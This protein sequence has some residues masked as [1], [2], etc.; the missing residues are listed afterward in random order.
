MVTQEYLKWLFSYDPETGLFTRLVARK[1]VAAGAIAG[2]RTLNGYTTISIKIDGVVSRF[3][4][5]RLAWLYIHGEWPIDVL[6]HVN[7]DRS[8]NRMIN[9]RA[10]QKNQN[11]FNARMKSSNK[12]GVKGVCWHKAMK[13]WHAQLRFNGEQQNLGFFDNLEE[14]ERIVRLARETHHGEFARH[15]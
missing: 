13:K 12:S 1:G 4:A 9:L 5:H 11:S 10:A 15:A 8:D 7:G 2:C 14:A 3:Y 6:D